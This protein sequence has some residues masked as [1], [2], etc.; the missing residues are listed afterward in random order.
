[1][2]ARTDD[3]RYSRSVSA[4]TGLL[5]SVVC[6]LLLAAAASAATPP[7]E[8]TYR[9]LCR[10]IERS[11][12]GRSS[13]HRSRRSIS[14]ARATARS[15]RRAATRSSTAFRCSSGSTTAT[16]RCGSTEATIP[17]GPS[18]RS[19]AQG[20]MRSG[21]TRADG[22][23]GRRRSDGTF[24]CTIIPADAGQVRSPTRHAVAAAKASA[25]RL[26]RLCA[27]VFAAYR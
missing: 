12:F 20:S 27:D 21:G 9:K 6:V 3:R 8:A 1:M 23:L 24:T 22:F 14:A 15:R 18:A 2:R 13:P 11:T 25:Q 10:S 19:P 26:V 5:I 16:R 7:S 17:T 4:R